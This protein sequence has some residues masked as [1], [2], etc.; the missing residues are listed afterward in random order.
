MSFIH[1]QIFYNWKYII[2]LYIKRGQYF[3]SFITKV[4]QFATTFNRSTLR[5]KLA[6]CSK[7]DTSSPLT[8][9]GSIT[10]VFLLL[11]NLFR[12][13]QYVFGTVLG[14]SSFAVILAKKSPW[15]LEVKYILLPENLGFPYH[16]QWDYYDIFWL[17]WIAFSKIV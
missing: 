16:Q 9:T 15:I 2:I 4:R 10:E 12:I 7:Y 8:R 13:D 6:F 17:I 1:I 14:L 3:F 11:K 5:S